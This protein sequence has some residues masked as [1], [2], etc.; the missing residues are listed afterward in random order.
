[1]HVP[2]WPVLPDSTL[3]PDAVLE[4]FRGA[5]LAG[6]GTMICDESGCYDDGTSPAPPAPP[7]SDSSTNLCSLYPAM[8]QGPQGV[9][10]PAVP[11][12]TV[13]T[14]TGTIA[15]GYTIPSQSSAAWANVAAALVK[16]GMTLAQIQSIQPGTVVSANGAILRQATGL[17]V[18]VTTSTTNLGLS[19][20][21]SSGILI[22]AA[23]GFAALLMMGGRR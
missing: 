9:V 16:G 13:T 12:Q 10:T 1:M 17:P 22:A 11:D 14:P 20:S 6:L 8:C 18:P 7:T 15:T 3:A 23:I 2:A 5:S 4:K 19:A 21:G